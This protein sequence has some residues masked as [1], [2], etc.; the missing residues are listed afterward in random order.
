MDNKKLSNK[1]EQDI[2]DFFGGRTQIASGA[3]PLVGMKGDVVTPS[4]CIECKATKK[5]FYVLKK[6]VVKKIEME[7]LKCNRI[8]LLAIRVLNKDYILFRALDFF[9][10]FP[11]IVPMFV[12]FESHKISPT[13]F[14]F[15]DKIPLYTVF[16]IDGTYWL[17]SSLGTFS[18]YIDSNQ[19][20][21]EFGD[22]YRSEGCAFESKNKR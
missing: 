11:L 16:E 5:N 8:P 7:A 22:L 6:K 20:L 2:A 12:V 13:V 9:R 18:D 15:L 10:E 17:L 4:A 19:W 14:Q 21:K 1:H 3:I